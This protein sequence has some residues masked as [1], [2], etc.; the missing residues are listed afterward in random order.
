[1]TKYRRSKNSA[2]DDPWHFCRDCC[3]DPKTNYEVRY[4][5]PRDVCS[6]CMI[7][8][9]ALPMTGFERETTVARMFSPI[10]S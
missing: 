4:D 3:E 8:K 7:G 9:L 10:K 6:H 5:P 2:A 1:M